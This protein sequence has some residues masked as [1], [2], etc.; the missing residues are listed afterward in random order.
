MTKDQARKKGIRKEAADTGQNYQTAWR[1]AARTSKV[2]VDNPFAGFELGGWPV[3]LDRVDRLAEAH[4]LATAAGVAAALDELGRDLDGADGWDYTEWS[5]CA[6]TPTAY[7]VYDHFGRPLCDG[8][9][10][11]TLRAAL[12]RY[13]ALVELL[14]SDME[15]AGMR[16]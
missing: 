6:K 10:G 4:D 1:A 15:F 11:D 9:N 7:F 2:E 8:P 12:D 14:R 5:I 3:R 16:D 13:E